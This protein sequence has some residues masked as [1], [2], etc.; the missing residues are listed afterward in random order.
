MERASDLLEAFSQAVL[1]EAALLE[2]KKKFFFSVV[3]ETVRCW[4]HRIGFGL[5]RKSKQ[6]YIDGHD[7]DDVVTYRNEVFLPEMAGAW[8]R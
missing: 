7:R 6:V 8:K 3:E 4:L 5:A 1:H 2:K